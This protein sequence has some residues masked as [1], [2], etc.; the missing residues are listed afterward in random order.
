MCLLIF[1]HRL[2]PRY[3][4][5][6]AANRDEFH[7]RPTRPSRFWSEHPLLIAG[8]DEE[9]GGTWMGATKEGRFAAVTNF[10]D[11]QPLPSN[12]RSRGELPLDFLKGQLSPDKYLNKL[13]QRAEQY[14]GFNLLIGDSRGLWYFCN[15]SRVES[16]RPDAP[17]KLQPGIYGLSNAHLDTP[18]PKVTLGKEKLQQLLAQPDGIEHNQLQTLVSDQSRAPRTQLER[19]GMSTDI[20]QLASAQFIQSATY[21][22]RST[23]TLWCDAQGKMSWRELSYDSQGLHTGTVREDF[24]KG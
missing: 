15:R 14:A 4:L 13:S 3:P 16:H 6:V 20:E 5:L 9:L 21:G 19:L 11:P 18:W 1:A 2:S 23:T 8:K 7:Q 24:G 22:T 10:R 17:R 12:M